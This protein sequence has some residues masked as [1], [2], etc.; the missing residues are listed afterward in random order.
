MPASAVQREFETIFTLPATRIQ[1][2]R[3]TAC[4]DTHYRR[5]AGHMWCAPSYK[6]A[7]AQQVP[8]VLPS[9]T[10]TSTCRNTQAM[11]MHVD[12]NVTL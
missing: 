2:W 10:E 4:R 3:R 11:A 8:L 5:A 9:L 7:A 12:K 1:E 6:T